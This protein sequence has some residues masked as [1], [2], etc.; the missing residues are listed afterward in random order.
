M[1]S[2]RRSFPALLR[3]LIEY[4]DRTCATPYCGAPIRHIDHITPAR[5][6]GPT[7][8]ANGRGVCA[9]CNHAKEAPGW[10][11]TATDT[12]STDTRSSDTRGSDTRG[13]DTDWRERIVTLTTPTGHP[14]SSHP[15][16]AHHDSGAL[17][18]DSVR[19]RPDRS[20]AG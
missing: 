14:Y 7:S 6:S 9:A 2:N 11:A 5:D 1:E 15:P 20:R 19:Q 4:R 12:T 16:P 3:R 17:M 10:H 8:Y 13:S 18:I